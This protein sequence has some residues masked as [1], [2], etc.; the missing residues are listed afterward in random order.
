MVWSVPHSSFPTVTMLVSIAK[1]IGVDRRMAGWLACSG[2][3]FYD[4]FMMWDGSCWFCVLVAESFCIF[5]DV[6]RTLKLTWGVAGSFFDETHPLP[7]IRDNT[8]SGFR[9]FPDN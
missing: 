8:R 4:V 3:V 9:D 1:L 5:V 6:Q 7:S 2:V